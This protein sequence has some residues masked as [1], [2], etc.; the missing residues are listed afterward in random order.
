MTI[1]LV[2]SRFRAE[3]Q[4]GFLASV[5]PGVNVT[6]DVIGEYVVCLGLYTKVSGKNITRCHATGTVMQYGKGYST[7]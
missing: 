7:P 5:G 4:T 6:T 3:G 1:K 2:T